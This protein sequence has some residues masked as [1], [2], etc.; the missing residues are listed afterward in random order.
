MQIKESVI[1]NYGNEEGDFYLHH[2]QRSSPFERN[3]HYHGTYEVY[4]QLSG[5]RHQF[6]KDSAYALAPGDLVFIN[7]FDVHKTSVLGSPQHE[8]VVMNFSDAFLGNGHP[9]FRPELLAI[10]R[11]DNPLYRLKPQE[12]MFVDQLFRRMTE[13]VRHQEEIGRAHV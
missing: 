11:K 7:K 1:I 8:R 5:R 3:N 10:F 13:E 12:Q 2:V 9:L 4:Y 6:I